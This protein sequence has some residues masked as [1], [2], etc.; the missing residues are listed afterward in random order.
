MQGPPSSRDPSAEGRKSSNASSAASTACSLGSQRREHRED[1][2]QRPGRTGLGG[3][4]VDPQSPVKPELVK[5]EQ[6][7]KLVAARR[8]A[9]RQWLLGGDGAFVGEC[10]SGFCG[11]DCTRCTKSDR[12]KWTPAVVNAL[13]DAHVPI[14]TK[15]SAHCSEKNPLANDSDAHFLLDCPHV[16]MREP[17]GAADF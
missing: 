17:A 8:R 5:E 14:A 11:T 9:N 3:E 10:A 12:W 7:R 4:G 6:R 13:P 15:P 1:Q 16:Q 2:G